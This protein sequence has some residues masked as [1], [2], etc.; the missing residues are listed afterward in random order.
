L[1]QN[2]PLGFCTQITTQKVS[3]AIMH[4]GD[5]DD[6]DDDDDESWAPPHAAVLSV[7]TAMSLQSPYPSQSR[8]AT[9]THP[10][11]APLSVLSV[12]DPD[13]VN[14]QARR[15][16]PFLAA[17]AAEYGI[18]NDDD[19]D[20]D[21]IQRGGKSK[22]MKENEAVQG[23]E[24]TCSKCETLNDGME[25]QC[26]NCDAR[27]AQPVAELGWGNTACAKL[28]A[29]KWKCETCN[30]HNDNELDTCAACEVP[31]EGGNGGGGGGTT[32]STG[33]NTATKMKT[34]TSA[35]GANGFSFGGAV[36][37]STTTAVSVGGFSFRA[38]AP[39]AASTVASSTSA[40]VTTGGFSFGAA[41]ATS[42]SATSTATS[43]SAPVTTG[44]FVVDAVFAAAVPTT[45]STAANDDNN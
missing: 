4:P 15:R 14:E 43:S 34:T 23:D 17:A 13:M 19:G 9:S 40:P 21:V 8:S 33:G 45:A 3:E 16:E 35:I 25:S 27:Y 30:T 41:P 44:G 28:L 2:P 26:T 6:D 32:A 24:W 18:D 22:R 10:S 1:L 31:R 12:L 20:S 38:P 29:N 11:Q 37:S 7:Q 42:S 36:Q 5:S 39:A